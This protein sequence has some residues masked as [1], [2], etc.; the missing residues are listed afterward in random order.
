MQLKLKQSPTWHIIIITFVVINLS[1][2]NGNKYKI[3]NGENC[4][5]AKSQSQEEKRKMYKFINLQ[6]PQRI[7][8]A[9]SMEHI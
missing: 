1:V 5:C 2:M 8:Q 7:V 4:T 3:D 6:N 9:I